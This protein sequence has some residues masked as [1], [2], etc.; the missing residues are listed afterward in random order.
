MLRTPP[1]H[2]RGSEEILPASLVAPLP[3]S[4]Q[5]V[6]V[7]SHPSLLCP[8]CN[9][10]FNYTNIRT[11]LLPLDLW[12]DPA[13]VTALLARWPEKLAGGPQSGRSDSPPLARVMAVGKQQQHGIWYVYICESYVVLDQCDE[14][15]PLLVC[16]L[17]LCV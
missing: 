6:D 13:G 8:L 11:T 17:C 2:I 14:P 3:N 16:A 15:R 10:L 12:T 9:H 5:K 1:P 4:E 7:K